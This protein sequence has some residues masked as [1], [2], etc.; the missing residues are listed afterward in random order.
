MVVRK[1]PFGYQL[2]VEQAT[3]IGELLQALQTAQQQVL[4]VP[5]EPKGGGDG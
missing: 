4:R 3:T 5:V 1:T 2:E